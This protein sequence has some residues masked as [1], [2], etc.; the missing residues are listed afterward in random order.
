MEHLI[1]KTLNFDLSVPTALN[2]LERYV[3]AAG[4]S[5]GGSQLESLAKV[6]LKAF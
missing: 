4:A 1:L 3:L 6:V 5:N 2:F